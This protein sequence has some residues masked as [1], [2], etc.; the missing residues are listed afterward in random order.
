MPKVIGTTIS[1]PV[2]SHTA[3]KAKSDLSFS[4]RFPRCLD[5]Y[6]RNVCFKC[7][8]AYTREPRAI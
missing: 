1:F 8:Q 2:S 3:N 6:M 7:V 5:L 4:A